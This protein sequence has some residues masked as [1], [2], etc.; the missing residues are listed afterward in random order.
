MVAGAEHSLALPH[1][2]AAAAL[3]FLS[4]STSCS[5]QCSFPLGL[6]LGTGCACWSWPGES[7]TARDISEN[8]DVPVCPA[9]LLLEQSP[10]LAFLTQA[11]ALATAATACFWEEKA[12]LLPKT[13]LRSQHPDPLLPAACQEGSAAAQE[14]YLLSPARS[15]AE[16]GGTADPTASLSAVCWGS[17]GNQ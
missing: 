4:L 1:R 3:C 15:L 10:D 9:G 17:T 12:E 7:K 2:P 16:A 5:K 11:T 8:Q 6:V 13:G 14:G